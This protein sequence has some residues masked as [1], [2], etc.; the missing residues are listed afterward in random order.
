MQR[1]WSA[2]AVLLLPSALLW[3]TGA[4]AQSATDFGSQW[5]AELCANS[6]EH[7]PIQAYIRFRYT[8]P[9][10]KVVGPLCYHFDGY[11]ETCLPPKEDWFTPAT[12]I[13]LIAPGQVPTE[14]LQGYTLL[15]RFPWRS[16]SLHRYPLQPPATSAQGSRPLREC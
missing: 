10:T 9:I 6:A 11:N 2:F 7:K 15:V 8:G 14:L 13:K 1:T 12:A 16:E 5:Q 4:S 3:T